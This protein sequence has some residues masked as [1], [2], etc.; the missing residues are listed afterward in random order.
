MVVE[1]AAG[2]VPPVPANM[3][4]MRR[5]ICFILYAAMILVGSGTVLAFLANGGRGLIFMACGFMASFGAYL[6]WADFVSPRNKRQ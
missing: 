5:M 2:K 1:F 4:V 6:M 3:P